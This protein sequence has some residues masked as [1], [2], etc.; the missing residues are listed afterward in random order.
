[1]GARVFVVFVL[2]QVSAASLDAQSRGNAFADFTVGAN[3]SIGTLPPDRASN[4]GGPTYAFLAFGNQPDANR[5]LIAALH[6]G[7][8]VV[9][10]SH[11][12]C[13]G[14]PLG[15]CLREFPFGPL[16]AITVGARPMKLSTLIEVTAGPAL[17]GINPTGMTFGMLA[18]GRLG[19]PPGR[20]LS[21]GLAIHLLAAPVDGSIAVA[22]G[23]GFS[24]RTW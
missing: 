20:Y 3:L 8:N 12:G 10:G 2:L 13:E 19:T 9:M 7:L 21:P 17:V 15:G 6:L 24:L 14:M 18:V 22:T 23:L 1:M 5:P 16:V 4:N 11:A